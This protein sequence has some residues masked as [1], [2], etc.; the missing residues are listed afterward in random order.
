[1]GFS[2][3][4]AAVIEAVSRDLTGYSHDVNEIVGSVD[5][6]VGRT[7]TAW[8][9]DDSTRFTNDW[10][11]HRS[12]LSSLS[13]ALQHLARTAHEQAAEQISISSS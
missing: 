5:T 1:M 13:D 4:D 8:V 6:I 10:H 9:G 2:G 11:S 3:M 12:M 7:S